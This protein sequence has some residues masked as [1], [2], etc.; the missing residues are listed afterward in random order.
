MFV[1][2]DS[3]QE[4][5]LEARFAL[6]RFKVSIAERAFSANGAD[7]PA[8]SWILAPQQGLAASVREVAGKLGLDFVSVALGPGRGAARDAGA[9]ARPVGA[10]GRHRHH[11]LGALHARPAPH[12]LRLRAR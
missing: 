10:M 4:G 12:P 6:A 1:L 3:G 5:L 9:A 7:Y 11:R 2:K 8:G